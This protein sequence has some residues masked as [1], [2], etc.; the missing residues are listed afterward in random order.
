MWLSALIPSYHAEWT[1]GCLQGKSFVIVDLTQ[2]GSLLS[3]VKSLYVFPAFGDYS[4]PSNS[5]FV[6]AFPRIYN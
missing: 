5:F 6:N 4:L 2:G 3:R 1:D